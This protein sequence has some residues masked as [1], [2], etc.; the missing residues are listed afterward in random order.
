MGALREG[1]GARLCPSSFL[2]YRVWAEKAISLEIW[3]LG[4]VRFVIVG[5][6][7]QGG[8]EARAP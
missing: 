2:V 8:R 6:G 1:P 4:S 3:R 5:V 7:I